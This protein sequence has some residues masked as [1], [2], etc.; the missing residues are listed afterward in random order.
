VIDLH[1]EDGSP[2]P[3]QPSSCI[4]TSTAG[5]VIFL[6]RDGMGQLSEASAFWTQFESA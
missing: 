1:R 6:R 5:V 4:F 2:S 3:N